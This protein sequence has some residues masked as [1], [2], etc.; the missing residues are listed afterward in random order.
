MGTYDTLHHLR[1]CSLQ[2]DG[3]RLR[4]LP[5]CRC[6]ATSS[7]PLQ[8]AAGRPQAEEAAAVP[9]WLRACR[10]KGNL[11]RIVFHVNKSKKGPLIFEFLDSSVSGI[12]ERGRLYIST[13]CIANA[14]AVVMFVSLYLAACWRLRLY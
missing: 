8:L 11:D 10:E 2:P 9:L 4:M 12:G 7:A 6:H 1:R 14:T 3:H 13:R 5:Q